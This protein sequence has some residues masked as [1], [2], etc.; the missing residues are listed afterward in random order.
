MGH[1]KVPHGFGLR[2]GDRGSGT[3]EGAGVR[4]R[5]ASQARITGKNQ[6]LPEPQISISL[7]EI[8]Y[9]DWAERGRKDY[10]CLWVF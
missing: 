9:P 3:A 7:P 8:W 1:K 10:V 4:R 2:T 6:R 5:P